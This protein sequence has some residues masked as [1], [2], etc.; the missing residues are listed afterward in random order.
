MLSDTLRLTTVAEGIEYRDQ[1]ETLRTLGC[2]LGQ[3]F[4]FSRPVAGDQIRASLRAHARAAKAMGT[5]GG[6]GV[7]IG[8]TKPEFPASRIGSTPQR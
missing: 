8:L 5:K 2:D 3:G 6:A 1:Q 4:L 7:H